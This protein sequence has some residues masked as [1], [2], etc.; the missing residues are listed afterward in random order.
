MKIAFLSALIVLLSAC[1]ST[2][3]SDLIRQA[4][5]NEITLAEVLETP[6]VFE[7][8]T[9]R[10][11]GRVLNAES[12]FSE[13]DN[14]PLLRVEIIH[15][16]LDEGG[17]PLTEANPGL[18]FI[19]HI[20][21]KEQTPLA[22]KEK[23]FE[24]NAFVTVVGSLYGTET[25]VLENGNTQSLP[26]VDADDFHRWHYQPDNHHKHRSRNRFSF[27]IGIGIKL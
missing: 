17:K 12:I 2:P 16:P 11:G 24:R 26:I 19:S 15:Y 18:R 8:S 22:L 21:P 1:A 6:I 7:Q 4:P 25:I 13:A 20:D 9:V 27:G 5:D 10:W 3:P 14:I 23:V